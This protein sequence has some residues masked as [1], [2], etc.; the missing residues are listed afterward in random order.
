VRL[1]TI[2]FG[3]VYELNPIQTILFLP[4]QFKNF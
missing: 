2:I 3:L 1:L 4:Y